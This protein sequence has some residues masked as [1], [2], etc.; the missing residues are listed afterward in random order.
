MRFTIDT[1][2][3]VERYFRDNPRL[4]WRMVL[5]GL[6]NTLRPWLRALLLVAALALLQ[7]LGQILTG[8]M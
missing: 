8:G 3:T 1:T 6:A 2:R 4:A 5:S 7:G